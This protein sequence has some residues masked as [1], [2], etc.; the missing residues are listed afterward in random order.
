MSNRALSGPS[1]PYWGS[2]ARTSLMAVSV[3]LMLGACGGGG[4]GSSNTSTPT[5]PAATLQLTPTTVS[6]GGAMGSSPPT[7]QIQ[8][9][10]TSSS[11]QKFYVDSSNSDHGLSAVN[12]SV[13]N[14][15]EILS[16]VFQSPSTLGVGTYTDTVTVKGC[17]DQACTQQVSGSPQTVSVTYTITPQ[18]PVVSTLNPSSAQAGAPAFV[19]TVNGS[20]FASQSLVL[21]NGT[22]LSTTYVSN[23]QLTAQVTAQDV[24]TAGTANVQVATGQ[25]ESN[26]VTFT[27]APVG[28][29]ALTSISPQEVTAGGGPFMLTVFGSGYTSN[30]VMTWNGTNLP[31]TYVSGTTLRAAVTA[32]QISLVG[33]ASIA[34]VNPA[35]QGGSSTPQTLTIVAPTVDAVSYQMNP[36]HTGSITFNNA[37]LP[38][39]STWSVNVG[40]SP[41]YALIVN[42]VVYVT[43]AANTGPQLLALNASDGTTLWGPVTYAGAA[44][45]ANAAY[46]NG[47]IFVVWTNGTDGGQVIQALNATTG[48]QQWST[49][50]PGQLDNSPPVALDGIV[51]TDNSGDIMAF[52]E[53]T[54]AMLWQGGAGGTTGTVAVTVDGVY[55]TSP[56]S[57]IALQP[58]VGTTLWY[59]NSGCEGADGATPVVANG[60]LYAPN[61]S[62]G[63]SGVIFD[64]EA[65]TNEG[66]YSADVIPAFSANTGFFLSGGILQGIQQ[67]NNTVLWSFMGDN[68]LISAPITVDNWVFIGSSSG[69]LYAVDATSGQ[70]VWVQSLAPIPSSNPSSNPLVPDFYTGLAAGDGLLVVPNGNNVTAFTLSTSP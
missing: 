49:A 15:V 70:Q 36:A 57:A 7:A 5:N 48:N 62:T 61:T 10:I 2:L 28:P 6:V 50:A 34:V 47:Q 4:S 20:Q 68:N 9:D 58:A 69:N 63:S 39:S 52:D 19:L 42:G 17:Y 27:V 41:S 13:Q 37:S 29:F 56:C 12:Q 43:V 59:N 45:S 46:D 55:G 14:G 64:A 33:T 11:T 18:S 23:S 54:G 53:N 30:S 35:N 51:Y 67:S 60:L 31:T 22:A 3:A 1:D 25:V 38:G 40:G 44:G 65:G 8:V 26:V 16:L 66:S 32:A 24:A 21:W